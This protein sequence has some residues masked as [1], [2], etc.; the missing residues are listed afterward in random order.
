MCPKTLEYLSR[1]VHIDIQAQ[2]TA[3]DCD[4]IAKGIRKVAET[5]L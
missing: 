4:M 2:L 5:L 1:S 3:E